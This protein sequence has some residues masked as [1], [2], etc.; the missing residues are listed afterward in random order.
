MLFFESVPCVF[1]KNGDVHIDVL[2]KKLP[3]SFG[4]KGIFLYLCKRK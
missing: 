2:D 4:G 1:A 3:V